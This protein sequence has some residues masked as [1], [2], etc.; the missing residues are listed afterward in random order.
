[1]PVIW[2][3]HLYTHTHTHKY[4]PDTYVT[5][6]EENPGH[7]F[8]DVAFNLWAAPPLPP[9]RHRPTP[10][11]PSEDSQM[12]GRGRCDMWRISSVRRGFNGG[13]GLHI[14]TD[15]VADSLDRPAWGRGAVRAELTH[16][17]LGLLPT[18]RLFYNY[19]SRSKDT[20][21]WLRYYSSS[22]A[23]LTY[24]SRSKGL[25]RWSVLLLQ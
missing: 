17:T 2:G 25:S 23:T 16:N 14:W 6:P 3:S 18:S 7:M 20:Y 15:R 8:P 10:H 22:S 9:P 4:T 13:V 5:P 12:C 11:P 1:M 19:S 21:L 24:N